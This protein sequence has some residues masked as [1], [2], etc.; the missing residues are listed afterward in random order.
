M[1]IANLVLGRLLGHFGVLFL[2]VV[3]PEMIAGLR[4]QTGSLN[5][6]SSSQA[7]FGISL[8]ERLL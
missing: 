1:L 8:I 5:Q 2:S 6:T 7:N 4:R 3:T